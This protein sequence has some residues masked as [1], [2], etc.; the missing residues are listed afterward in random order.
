MEQREIMSHHDITL[1]VPDEIYDR[2]RR[3]AEGT[4]QSVEAVLLHYLTQAFPEPLPGLPPEEQRE[5]DALALLSDDALWTMA[6]EWMP[7]D[8]QAR[9]HVLMA[10]NSQ[11]IVNRLAWTCPARWGKVGPLSCVGPNSDTRPDRS[12]SDPSQ[13]PT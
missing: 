2:A 5:L 9:L 10:A 6:R 11:G 4:S 12:T 3:I 7:P 1:P 13:P 8:R